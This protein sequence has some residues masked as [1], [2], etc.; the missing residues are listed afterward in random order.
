MSDPIFARLPFPKGPMDVN[1]DERVQVLEIEGE[2]VQIHLTERL[3]ERIRWEEI[4]PMDHIDR[5][6]VKRQLQELS[7]VCKVTQNF[8]KIERGILDTTP[9]RVWGQPHSDFRIPTD[10]LINVRNQVCFHHFTRN[11]SVK[12]MLPPSRILGVFLLLYAVWPPLSTVS[13][14]DPQGA[15]RVRSAADSRLRHTKWRL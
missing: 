12:Q 13:L 3:M 2:S 11:K 1:W 9:R 7:P 5:D 4:S 8:Y 15:A 14:H 10:P 6:F